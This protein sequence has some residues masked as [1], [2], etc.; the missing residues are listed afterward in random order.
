MRQSELLGLRWQDIDFGANTIHV[1]NQLSRAAT[2]K[3][4]RLVPLK[5]DAAERH[6]DLAPE[7]TRELVTLVSD[8]GFGAPGDVKVNSCQDLDSCAST[9][10]AVGSTRGSHRRPDAR[11]SG[12]RIWTHFPDG[13]VY[14]FTEV[15][16]LYWRRRSN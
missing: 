5:T 11:R 14:R 8:T 16:Q 9:A 13:V 1:R 10:V 6:I 7:L 2:K 4:A 15:R 12:G 3:P